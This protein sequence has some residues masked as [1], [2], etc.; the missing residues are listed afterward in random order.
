MSVIYK[1]G[2]YCFAIREKTIFSALRSPIGNLV[3][4]DCNCNDSSSAFEIPQHYI[5]GVLIYTN[6]APLT[7][8]KD[9]IALLDFLFFAEIDIASVISNNLVLNFLR[10]YRDWHCSRIP[11]ANY[12]QKL[13]GPNGSGC[14]ELLD[15]TK[16]DDEHPNIDPSLIITLAY[17]IDVFDES[18]IK[19]S[20]PYIPKVSPTQLFRFSHLT[21]LSI[22]VTSIELLTGL[23]TVCLES[24]TCSKL[25][26]R[27]TCDISH[28]P[29]MRMLKT[30]NLGAVRCMGATRAE[31]AALGYTYTAEEIDT[32]GDEGSDS[33]DEEENEKRV[34]SKLVVSGAN[35]LEKLSTSISCDFGRI[36]AMNVSICIS[37][38][39]KLKSL[40]VARP[41]IG[42]GI[43]LD[44]LESISVG[45]ATMNPDDY[46]VLIGV[47]EVTVIDAGKYNGY[48][49]AVT[50]RK[51][52]DNIIGRTLSHYPNL[53]KLTLLVCD[54]FNYKVESQGLT[55]LDVTTVGIDSGSR[56]DVCI[57]CAFG[58]CIKSYQKTSKRCTCAE[59]RNLRSSV[60]VNA[61]NLKELYASTGDSRVRILGTPPLVLCEVADI[62]SILGWEFIKN[63]KKL[64]ILDECNCGIPDPALLI[65]LEELELSDFA[66][67]INDLDW[68]FGWDDALKKYP[69]LAK[70]V[71]Q[72]NASTP[73]MDY[74]GPRHIRTIAKAFSSLQP[75]SNYIH[76]E[77]DYIVLKLP[78]LRSSVL[79]NEGEG[80][81][82]KLLQM[83]VSQ[84]HDRESVRALIGDNH[85][86]LIAI[87]VLISEFK[88]MNEIVEEFSDDDVDS[89]PPIERF[90][91]SFNS[92][93]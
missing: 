74:Y 92:F 19:G 39:P 70:F 32:E 31:S 91:G 33:G 66:Y 5:N 15:L 17:N 34:L 2:D 38:L 72:H 81:A 75:A 93:N 53:V 80:L 22:R 64:R 20:R 82:T 78:T 86:K 46:G 87:N 23:E 8:G 59:E 63:T 6:N 62:E 10:D 11:T 89:Q 54:M 58:P 29:M 26:I 65:N 50:P 41:L 44:Q 35:H 71:D 1:C 3:E 85:S 16:S 69:Y 45:T 12:I 48:T 25:V 43:N 83:L 47:T 55:Y 52:S 67:N 51:G 42:N 36:A 14:V 76:Y 4:G 28:L 18:D 57:Y 60:I 90:P 56:G 37:N 84:C 77:I 7:S 9:V 88:Y 13:L 79:T 21:T 68:E 61:P 24:F 27:G 40:H 30:L 73:S 49:G